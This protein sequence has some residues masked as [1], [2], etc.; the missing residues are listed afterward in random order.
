MRYGAAPLSFKL[1]TALLNFKAI[2]PFFFFTLHYKLK[3]VIIQ[4][5]N[6]DQGLVLCLKSFSATIFPHHANIATI[7]STAETA[8]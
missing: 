1:I 6:D 2:T 4:A 5:D 3:N 7:A 8:F